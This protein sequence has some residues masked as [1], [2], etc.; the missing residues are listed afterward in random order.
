MEQKL[1]CPKHGCPVVQITDYAE[2]V[3]MADWVLDKTHRQVVMDIVKEEGKYDLVLANGFVLPVI[4][5]FRRE[6][7][8]SRLKIILPT[9]SDHCLDLF[10]G[11]VVLKTKYSPPQRFVILLDD[12]LAQI[13]L[14]LD[15]E[16]LL[17]Y[18]EDEEVYKYEPD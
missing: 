4:E 9:E 10:A 6:E 14:E 1:M 11:R 3:C 8:M 18:L 5:F 16:R 12:E 17:Y 13:E 15:G 2:P 7:N